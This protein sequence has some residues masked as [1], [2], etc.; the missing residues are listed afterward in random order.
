M[1]V[2]QLTGTIPSNIGV[3]FGLTYVGAANRCAFALT[4][5]CTHRD[6]RSSVGYS[7]DAVHTDESIS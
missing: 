5:S 3:L 7:A 6:G 1:C 2:N 4:C